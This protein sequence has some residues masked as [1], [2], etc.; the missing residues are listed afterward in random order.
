VCGIEDHLGLLDGSGLPKVAQEL[1]AP[2]IP[3]Q[4]TLAHATQHA[5]IRLAPRK[6]V[7]RAILRTSP[8]ASSF[9]V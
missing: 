2:D 8:H 3:W 9:C 6:E 5:Q 7:F 4:G 1:Q